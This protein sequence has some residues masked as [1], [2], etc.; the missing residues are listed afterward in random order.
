[1]HHDHE[2]TQFNSLVCWCC[3]WC[4]TSMVATGAAHSLDLFG[5]KRSMTTKSNK[6]KEIAKKPVRKHENKSEMI[7][8]VIESMRSGLSCF[9]ACEF[10]GVPN[11]TFMSWVDADKLLAE[12]YARA[13]EDLIERMASETLA[14]AD[15]AFIEIEEQTLDG[16]GK[17]VVIKKKVPMDVNRAKLMVDTRKWHLS[18]LSPKKYGDKLELS[19]DPDRPLSIQ[20][21]ERVVVK[22]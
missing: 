12:R 5:K 19:G 1:M 22:S 13:R 15:Q 16:Q 9:K 17:P 6:T 4:N 11:S 2:S 3:N 8:L 20:K 7:D 10:V 18:K 21:I 14:I